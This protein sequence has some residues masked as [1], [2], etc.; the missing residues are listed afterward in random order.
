MSTVC[1]ASKCASCRSCVAKCPQGAIMIDDKKKFCN[2]VIDDSK[3]VKCGMCYKVCQINSK[4][5]FLKPIS[6]YQGW[7]LDREVRRNASSGGVASALTKA[8]LEKGGYVCSCCFDGKNFEFKIIKNRD[9]YATFLGSKYVKSKLSIKN[10][11]DIKSILKSGGEVLL[12]GLPCQVNGVKKYLGEQLLGKLYTVDLI[13]HGT[14]SSKLLME[15]LGQYKIK[16]EDLTELRFRD[17]TKFGLRNNYKK[18]VDDGVVDYYSLAFL[19][20]LIYTD[21]CYDCQYAKLERISDLTLGDSWGTNLD[22]SEKEKGIS[23]VLCQ[24]EK[25]MELLSDSKLNLLDVDLKTAIDNN[26]QLK[27][28]YA[29]DKKQIEFWNLY[30]QGYRFDTVVKR[31]LPYLCFRQTVKR[32]L[33]KLH[34]R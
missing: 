13:C 20:G 18:I 5:N 32:V 14:P 28:P 1:E 2:A 31:V 23:L 22:I 26:Q 10:Y 15:F 12:I 27:E 25:G 16:L 30:N 7:A 4:S 21:N 17:K 33:I 19:N 34:L 9:E 24:T 6:W 8:F 3:C 29:R 11:E